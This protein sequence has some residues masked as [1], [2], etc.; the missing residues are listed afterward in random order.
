MK[1]SGEVSR[2][3]IVMMM[4]MSSDTSFDSLSYR[5]VCRAAV[6]DVTTAVDIYS[7]G[8]CALEVSPRS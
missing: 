7:F 2:P 6:S 4:K 5:H 8:M 1:F 3:I